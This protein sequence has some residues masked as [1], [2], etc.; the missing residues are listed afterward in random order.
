[1]SEPRVHR[2]DRLMY[3]IGL[4]RIVLPENAMHECSYS[5]SCETSLD[6]CTHRIIGVEIVLFPKFSQKLIKFLTGPSLSYVQT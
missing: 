4:T 6:F 1:M 5:F 2:V 3:C